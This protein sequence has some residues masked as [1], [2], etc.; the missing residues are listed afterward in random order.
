[1]S[2]RNSVFFWEGFPF[3][4]LQLESDVFLFV[5]SRVTPLKKRTV[6]RKYG[7]SAVK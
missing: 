7:K 4:S 3:A 1:M 5:P 6:R 2:I